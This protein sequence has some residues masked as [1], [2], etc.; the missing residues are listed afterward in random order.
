MFY[1]NPSAPFLNFTHF[2]EPLFCQKI[3]RPALKYTYDR[4]Q[5]PWCLQAIAIMLRVAAHVYSQSEQNT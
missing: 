2:G 1:D 4:V 5:C 3:G